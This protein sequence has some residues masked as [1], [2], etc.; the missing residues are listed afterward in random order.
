MLLRKLDS[1]QFAMLN[2]GM[3]VITLLGIITSAFERWL[4]IQQS[5]RSWD[6]RIKLARSLFT[7]VGILFLILIIVVGLLLCL[8]AP[9][10]SR[11]VVICTI[12]MALVFL[13]LFP[14]SLVVS[15]E[16]YVLLGLLGLVEP[17]FRFVSIAAF[18]SNVAILPVFIG[19]LLSSFVVLQVSLFLLRQIPAQP[20]RKNI[21]D[22]SLS[23]RV[24]LLQVLLQAGISI[25]WVADGVILKHLLSVEA[26][27]AYVAHAYIMK[28]PLFLTT[29]ILSVLMVK[30]VT[31][32]A[33]YRD[34]R[35]MTAIGIAGS[36]LAF[37]SVAIVE[38]LFPGKIITVLGYGALAVPGLLV[39]IA[40]AWTL[41]SIISLLLTML[42]K[43]AWHVSV[44][45]VIILYT[46]S[47]IGLLFVGSYDIAELLKMLTIQAIIFLVCIVTI[48]SLL[49]AP[50]F[51][52]PEKLA[53]PVSGT[54]RKRRK[55]RLVR[56]S[57][58]NL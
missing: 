38:L 47:F 55:S 39:L 8:W 46:V 6:E 14:K 19:H 17:F 22:I 57:P 49:P 54:K 36:I 4:M 24:V 45:T 21:S 44:Q 37:G 43:V 25:F 52:M 30:V 9:E 53:S 20:S 2:Y 13:S 26:Y 33:G 34:F 15:Q 5:R 48:S 40:V 7:S 11:I 32:Q 50:Y 28:F 42:I 31:D 12:S 23:A 51:E 56:R 18:V 10:T 1:P 3:Y 35:K 29:S 16:N 41:H 58:S 27:S